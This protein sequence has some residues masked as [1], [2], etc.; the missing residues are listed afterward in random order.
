MREKAYFSFIYVCFFPDSPEEHSGRCA[1]EAASQDI[2]VKTTDFFKKTTD[3]FP[4]TSDISAE[5]SDIKSTIYGCRDLSPSFDLKKGGDHK[6]D[7]PESSSATSWCDRSSLTSGM[8]IVVGDEG[9]RELKPRGSER[10]FNKQLAHQSIS[11]R[12]QGLSDACGSVSLVTAIFR[13]FCNCL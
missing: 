13:P 1:N 11:Y 6:N 8:M 3:I 5:T 7:T 12:G 4:K 9:E 10:C 2:P